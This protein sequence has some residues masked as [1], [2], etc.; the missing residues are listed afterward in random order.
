MLS[1][2]CMFRTGKGVQREMIFLI[3]SNIF[4]STAYRI[5]LGEKRGASSRRKEAEVKWAKELNVLNIRSRSN[6]YC[7]EDSD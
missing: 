1:G 6:C 5:K 3:K 7:I 4:L 2:S